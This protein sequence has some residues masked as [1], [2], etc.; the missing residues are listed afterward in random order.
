[1][2]HYFLLKS[3][4]G[5][6]LLFKKDTTTVGSIGTRD[7]GALEIGSGDVYLQFNGANDWIKPVDGSGSNKSG[8][9][10][11]TSGAKFDN[12]YLSGTASIGN[13]TIA[14]AQ[15]TDGQLLTSTGSG[16]AWEDAPAGGPTF[17]TFGTDSIMIGDTTT[18]TIDAADN[19]V[20]LGVDVFAALTS[21]DYNVAI[22]YQA[23]GDAGQ[24]GK[25]LDHMVA[26]GT[27]TLQQLESG[28]HNIAIGRESQRAI[29]TGSNNITIG[30]RTLYQENDVIGSANIVIGS[31]AGYNANGSSF[32][33]NVIIGDYAGYQATNR[34]NVL[35]GEYSYSHTP[36]IV[37][38]RNVTTL[39]S[40]AGRYATGSYNTFL[41][42]FAGYGGNTSAPLNS[43]QYNTAVGH[44][45]LKGFTTAVGNTAI[46]YQASL[47]VTT[48]GYNT[49]LGYRAGYNITSGGNN[50]ALGAYALF[51]SQTISYDTAIGFS[52]LMDNT[53][54]GSNV[55]VGWNAM[56]ETTA[57]G[58][59]VAVGYEALK[60][61]THQKS[62]AIGFQ[63]MYDT[64]AGSTS[65]G[66][67]DNIFIGA[68]AQQFLF[69]IT[70]NSKKEYMPI[71]AGLYEFIGYQTIKWNEMMAASLVGI[72]P[73]LIIFIF[74]QKYLVEGLTAGAVKN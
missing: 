33:A 43:G 59:N 60:W 29:V 5:D 23:M 42:S 20:G 25:T 46:G 45:A 41:G 63:A 69:A 14:G 26:I 70:F 47:D 74:L 53:A 16:I 62:I 18:G 36:G 61:G 19:N 21:G 27:S 10:L 44:E 38:F 8:V 28:Y 32:H 56:N 34:E 15:G 52:A 37:N 22:G 66:S 7:S 31:N 6:I 40:N 4:D 67:D 71:P 65:M 11:G 50:T 73:V 49:S 58:S 1:M 64:N 30:Y 2:L 12:L 3:D 35:I 13:L 51:S 17:K 54:G 55:A 9:D 39:G 57:A 48:G 24:D 72:A 68:Y